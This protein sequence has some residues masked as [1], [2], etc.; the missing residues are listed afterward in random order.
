MDG[1]FLIKEAHIIYGGHFCMCPLGLV[2]KPGT[3]DLCMIHHFSKE[4]LFGH[5]MNS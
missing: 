4:D 1:Q 5:S 3:V 2:E